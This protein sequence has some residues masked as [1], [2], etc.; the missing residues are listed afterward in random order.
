MIRLILLLKSRFHIDNRSTNDT[1]TVMSVII[2]GSVTVLAC[3]A[4]IH[5]LFPFHITLAPL[6]LALMMAAA[7]LFHSCAPATV[8]SVNTHAHLFR[9][10]CELG[11]LKHGVRVSLLVELESFHCGYVS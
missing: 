5:H 6:F 2:L 3:E 4:D 10:A 7:F 1:A 11:L 8:H 9:D